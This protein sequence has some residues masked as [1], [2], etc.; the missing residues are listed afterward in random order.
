[1]T[2]QL[3]ALPTKWNK[4]QL[5]AIYKR[6]AYF[7]LLKDTN[8]TETKAEK[9]TELFHKGVA[10]D[11][12]SYVFE[13]DASVDKQ[14]LSLI[15]I[16]RIISWETPSVIPWDNICKFFT[17]QGN[18]TFREIY[19]Q[20]RTTLGSIKSPVEMEEWNFKAIQYI[21]DSIFSSLD[22]LNKR[23]INSNLVNSPQKVND[24]VITTVYNEEQLQKIYFRCKQQGLIA[25]SPGGMHD[26]VNIFNN[27]TLEEE[28]CYWTGT[29]RQLAYFIKKITNREYYDNKFW[30]II[31][32][33]FQTQKSDK[34]FSKTKL[35]NLRNEYG[36]FNKPKGENIP[37]QDKIDNIFEFK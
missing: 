9:F 26:F 14:L 20:V 25:D 19:N 16:L 32:E 5:H 2:Q 34:P 35:D 15:V 24:K 28:K 17:L 11:D 1:M 4:P 37:N 8:N 21:S 33:Y 31:G 6:L 13:F 3:I 36:A 27:Y 22:L 12:V 23:T 18:M 30:N 7:Q 10:P 29:I